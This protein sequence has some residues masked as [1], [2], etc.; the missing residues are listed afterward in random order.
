MILTD[1]L[2]LIDCWKCCPRSLLCKWKNVGLHDKIY[3]YTYC[4][5]YYDSSDAQMYVYL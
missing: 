5:S 3:L 1:I 4:I 2:S